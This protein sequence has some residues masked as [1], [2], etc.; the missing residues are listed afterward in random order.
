MRKVLF[1]AAVL[2]LAGSTLAAAAVWDIDT[3]HS[4]A[5]FKVR[6]LAVSNVAGSMGKVTGKVT[7]DEADPAT[8]SVEATLDAT[9][10]DTGVEDRDKHLKSADFFDVEKYPTVTF[11]STKV[12][13][14]SGG[15]E[16]TGDLT[17]HGVTKQVV[18]M[19]EGPFP[20]IKDSRG[21]TKSGASATTKINRQ[22]FGVS[23]SKTLDGGG[24]V[25]GNEVTITLDVE[26]N[27]Q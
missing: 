21:N 22:D 16:V 13:K 25:V 7:W 14:A 6:H 8:A 20:P 3:A 18:L 26:L 2:I 5:T 9:T 10:I 11:K 4:S 24:L 12:E 17:M 15:L 19:V 1:P 23:W 27:K